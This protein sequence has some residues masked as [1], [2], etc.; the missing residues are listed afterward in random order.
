MPWPQTL[1]W[2][3]PGLDTALRQAGGML[4]MPAWAGQTAPGVNSALLA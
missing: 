1:R 4:R 2:S 3:M